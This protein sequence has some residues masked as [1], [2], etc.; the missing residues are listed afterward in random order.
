MEFFEIKTD[1]PA[2]SYK[3]GEKMTFAVRTIHGLEYTGCSRFSWKLEGDDGKISSGEGSC[4]PT[5]PFK[6]ETS[7]DCPGFVHLTL[8]ALKADGSKDEN[9]WISDSGAGADVDK[10]TYN[11]KVPD[12]FDK[13][14]GNIEN[15]V[16]NF[17]P[18]L[19]KN[20]KLGS[21]YA[22]DWADVYDVRISTFVNS[23][24]SGIVS[25]PSKPGKYPMEI[26]FIGYGIAGAATPI[27]RNNAI[28]IVFNAHGIENLVEHT[29]LEAKYEHLKNYGFDKKE[30]EKPETT[31]WQN[32]M[33]RDL[34]G[35]KWAKTLEKWDGVNITS[36][37]GSQAAL[38]ATTVAAHDK[39]V[40]LLK[41]NVPWFCDLNGE[42][43]GYLAGWRPKR[44]DGLEYFDTVAQGMKVTCPVEI[45]AGLGDYCCPPRS[46]MC[47]YNS[48]KSEKKIEFVQ[49]RVHATNEYV[50]DI[51]CLESDER[52]VEPGIYEHY[53]GNKYE[54]LYVGKN[55]ETLEEE[56]VYKALYGDGGIWVRPKKMWN[57]YIILPGK[58]VRRFNK[59]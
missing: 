36:I 22:P 4:L 6:I 31:Y 40:T 34:C 19:L 44:A 12:D 14:W 50:G 57:D 49:S 39:D 38:Q 21:D 20:E 30:N 10:I 25:I 18:Q 3:S 59:I 11:G 32:M 58:R 5:V 35:V 24:A 13:Y 47:L 23:V 43:K 28:S 45:S 46:V 48:I 16:S 37:G 29:V 27:V 55:S 42:S 53:K 52:T 8:E 26:S 56:V 15:S 41:I 7:C 33:I 54:V 2:L 51:F 9:V 17:V 1:K